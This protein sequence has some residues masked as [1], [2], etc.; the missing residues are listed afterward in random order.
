MDTEKVKYI[1][2]RPAEFRIRLRQKPLAYLPLGTLEWHGEHLPLGA[3]AIQSETLMLECARRF[4]GIVMPPIFLGPDRRMET[5]TGNYFVGMDYAQ[6]TQPRQMLA[7]S[8][9]WVSPGFFL[10]ILDSI[11]EQLQRAGFKAVFADGHGPSRRIWV[12]S[13]ERNEKKFGLKLEGVTPD[14]KSSWPYMVDHAAENETS[15]MMNIRPDLV[16]LS[17]YP[18]GELSPVMGVNGSHPCKASANAGKEYLEKAIALLA[19]KLKAI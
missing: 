4:G 8:A 17:V 2:L 3:D 11:L 15:I 1:E 16:D 5:E 7:G 14:L 19:P 10:S 12:E 6:S 9:Y 18:K 13:I